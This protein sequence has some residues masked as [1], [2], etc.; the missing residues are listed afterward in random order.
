MNKKSFRNFFFISRAFCFRGIVIFNF[1]PRTHFRR[2]VLASL[3]Q[4]SILNFSYLRV[5]R[6][7][8]ALLFFARNSTQ[9]NILL[10]R[11]W[12]FHQTANPP[13]PSVL[14][15]IGHRPKSPIRHFLRAPNVREVGAQTPD[16]QLFRL[17]A[18]ASFDGFPSKELSNSQKP[19]VV[20]FIV[21][22]CIAVYLSLWL[23]GP[24]SRVTQSNSCTNYRARKWLEFSV[25]NFLKNVDDRGNKGNERQDRRLTYHFHDPHGKD[26]DARARMSKHCKI[27][28]LFYTKVFHFAAR[29]CI[30]L[31][32][33]WIV[34]RVTQL[35]FDLI[36]ERK[37]QAEWQRG[38][39]EQWSRLLALS[40]HLVLPTWKP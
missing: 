40:L 10:F 26:Y 20:L 35:F 29:K 7:D 34:T 21:K 39:W 36:N 13:P 24:V 37:T 5:S 15:A 22:A 19:R 25:S 27:C 1:L 12:N 31:S 2:F 30:F 23:E 32:S 14:F 18:F 28:L 11:P 33:G 16:Y 17:P 38:K 4:F 8:P 9:K 3:S 6:F